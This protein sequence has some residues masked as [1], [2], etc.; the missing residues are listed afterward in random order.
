MVRRAESGRSGVSPPGQRVPE[1]GAEGEWCLSVRAAP[2]RLFL[3]DRCNCA[4]DLS[5]RLSAAFGVSSK[6]TNIVIGVEHVQMT[7]SAKGE[8]WWQFRVIVMRS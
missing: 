4:F 2:F 7:G 1:S 8:R 5:D 3:P 6:L